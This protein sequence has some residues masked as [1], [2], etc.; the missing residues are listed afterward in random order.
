MDGTS[1]TSTAAREASQ[2]VE[3]VPG[4]WAWLREKADP[5]LYRPAAVPGTVIRCLTGREGSYYI[6]KNPASKTYCRLSERDYFLWERMD[7]TRTVK[8]L[9]V[10]YFMEYRAFAFARV[11]SLVQGLKAGYFLAEYPVN[12]YQQVRSRLEARRLGH[13][14]SRIFQAFLQKQFAVQG[15]DRFVAGAYRGGGRFLFTWPFQILFL[16]VS[17]AGLY[18]FFRSLGLGRYGLVTIAGSLWMGIAGLIVVNLLALFLHEMAHAL[19]VKHYGCEVTRGGFMIYFGLPAFFVDTTDI[20]LGGRRARLAVTWAGPYSGLFL[21]GLA[22][23]MLLAWPDLALNPL[24]FQFAFLTYLSVFLNLNPLLELDGYYLLMDWLEIPMLRR[25]SLAFMR[26]G[27]W[28]RLKSLKGARLSNLLTSLS[29]EERI[30][31]VFGLLSAIWT[32]YAVFM[33]AYFWQQRVSGALRNLWAQG[34]GV[35]KIALNLGILAIG[36]LFILSIGLAGLGA[37]RRLLN[38]ASGKGLFANTWTLAGIFLGV[39]VALA[40]V[41]EMLDPPAF[42]ALLSLLA[43]TGGTVF[44]WQVARDRAG[45]SLSRVFWLL[46][47]FALLLVLSETARLAADL[48][49]LWFQFLSPVCDILDLIA[50][51]ALLLAGLLLFSD[52]DLRQL[53][54]VEKG[55]LATGMALA[56]GFAFWQASLYPAANSSVAQV[57]VPV[58]RV[59]VPWLVLTALAPTLFSFWG[60]SSAPAW[61]MVALALI[62]LMG[63]TLLGLPL[64]LPYL[65]LAAGLLLH[66]LAYTRAG[67]ARETREAVLDLSDQRRLERAFAWTVSGVLADVRQLAGTRCH[68]ILRERFNAYANAAGW[69][70]CVSEEGVEDYLPAEMSLIE[71]GETYA[72]ALSLLLD[73][74]AQEVGERSTQKAL[75]R[76]YDGLPWE[77]REIGAQYL[78][79]DVKRAEALSRAFQAT[80][81]NYRGLLHRMPIFAT[82]SDQDLDLLLSRLRLERHPAGRMIV[83]QGEMGDRFYI[84]RR[85]HVEVT[86][87]DE[88]GVTRIVNQLDRGDYFGEVALLRDQP[89]NATCRATVPTETLS[90]SRQDF[91]ALVESRFS[92]R[93]N[94]DR[95]LARAE[96]LRRIPLFSELNGLQIQHV[97][98]QLRQED[99]GAGEFFIRQGEAGETFYVIESGRVQVLVSQD[100]QERVIAERGPGEYVGEIALLLEMPR[101]ASVRTLE[102]TFLLVL[103]KAD[104]DHLVSEH[105][106]IS[107]GLEQETSRR[108]IDLRRAAPQAQP[109][110][111]P[112]RASST[113]KDA[114]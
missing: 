35:A 91:S 110:T 85:G 76:A 86:Q 106:F 99:L 109:G 29:R 46:G 4:L 54:P 17:V 101:T 114:S 94:V 58:S 103:H 72:G 102:P 111:L 45:S 9:V 63:A 112:A 43:L 32:I 71:R 41:G 95:S 5:A 65:L 84:V 100:G 107:R 70:V 97:A 96:L 40:A 22:S 78:F 42:A 7:G 73:L 68:R 6:A 62:G 75:Q 24:L 77:E 37:V 69:R 11:A 34:Q 64:F 66:R 36:L 39:I 18:A 53:S 79:R 8:D 82:M 87:R 55:A 89:R 88:K 92:L 21:G 48:E 14:L 80:R 23:L 113:R 1:R 60:T 13:Q 28:Q 33:G 3:E 108:M 27:V 31:V 98:A 10:A 30:F 81:Q 44:A 20:W 49:P 19:T 93:E 38:W 90:L 25:R 57:M 104:F 16:V 15:L 67:L 56:F 2:P 26:R 47:S 50:Y 52:T 12:V 83:R 61:T 105:L 51:L 74:V 59:L